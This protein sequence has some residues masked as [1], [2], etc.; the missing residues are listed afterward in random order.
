MAQKNFLEIF[1]ILKPSDDVRDMLLKASDIKVRVDKEKRFAEIKANFP[2]TIRKQL[3]Y[4]AE[5][6]LQRDYS[7]NCV[8]ILPTYPAECFDDRY[9]SQILVEAE[10]TGI[11]ARGFFSNFEFEH[12]GG[13]ILIKIPFSEG[14]ISLLYDANTPKVIEKIIFSEFG[15]K[16]NVSVITD[17]AAQSRADE[18]KAREIKQ[19]HDEVRQASIN[20]GNRSKT[21]EFGP[22]PSSAEP[23]APQHPRAISV[24]SKKYEAHFEDGIYCSGSM[25]FDLSSPNYCIGDAFEINPIALCEFTSPMKGI[26][27]GEVFGFTQEATRSG[28]KMNTT[29]SVTDGY[30]SIEI[31]NYIDVDEAKELASF[32]KNGVSIALNGYAKHDTRRG[33]VDEDLTFYASDIA[34][35]ERIKRTDNAPQKRVE[36]H[37]HTNMSAMDALIPPDI[38]VKTAKAWGH[39]AVAITDHGNLQGYP[40]AMQ[41]AEKIKGI[42]VIYG[43]EAYYVNDTASAIGGAGRPGF[44]DE[45]IV[46]DIETTGLSFL[47]CK[48]TEIGAV[49]IKNGEIVDK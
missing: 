23:P 13:N 49:K 21:T 18:L 4:R 36:L 20:Y 31:R 34:V 44:D 24:Y 43:L 38:A 47:T 37:L 9:I 16:K 29:Y 35:V 11:V 39:K 12:D 45:I 32:V 27:V 22:N 15:I 41:T 25:R 19:L 1:N 7:L 17:E 28:D 2:K 30:T 8:R 10:R 33:K 5:A 26:I 6:E 48:I 42:K 3:L 14:G 40:I 46:F